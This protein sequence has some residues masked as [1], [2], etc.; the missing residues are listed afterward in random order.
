MRVEWGPGEVAGKRFAGVDTHAGEHALCVLDCLGRV[1][2]REEFPADAAGY[3]ALAAALGDPA[4]VACVGVEGTASYGAGLA[5]H[6]LSAGFAVM[7]VLRPGRR[8]ARRGRGKSDPADAERA[9]RQAL[10]GEDLSEPKSQDGWVD[11]L[12]WLLA[13]REGAVR[14]ATAA[15]NRA[16]GLLVTAP[17]GLRARWRGEP[18]EAVMRALS[19]LADPADPRLAALAAIGREWALAR[20]D[21]ASLEASMRGLLEE[22]CPALLAMPGCGPVSAAA[23]AVAAGDNPGRMRSEASFAALCGASPVEAS[24]GRVARHRLNRGGDRA[25]NAALHTIALNRERNDERTRAYVERRTAEGKSRREIRR[26]VKRYVAREAYRA[27]TR[28]RDVPEHPGPALAAAR[29]AAGVTQAAAAGALGCSPQALSALER[30]RRRS[31]ALAA[32]YAAWV[33]DGMP[34]E[35]ARE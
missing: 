12:R 32:R 9:A 6:L 17:E 18:T 2:L 8:G 33:A 4:G 5:R 34:L 10:A 7:E 16:L 28:P 20:S 21:A 3:E 22:G 31:P 24:S 19:E 1:E 35:V 15:A 26:C 29:R 23:L 13:A 14:A 11:S 27:L 30:G 25:A